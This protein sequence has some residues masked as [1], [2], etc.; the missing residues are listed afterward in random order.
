MARGGAPTSGADTTEDGCSL[1]SELLKAG[2]L[3]GRAIPKPLAVAPVNS[4]NAHVLRPAQ[5]GRA[6]R[7]PRFVSVY[8]LETPR[9]RCNQICP[10][11]E[12]GRDIRH[13]RLP[14]PPVAAS[15]MTRWFAAR[16]VQER[17]A[18]GV[19]PFTYFVRPISFIISPISVLSFF[20]NSAK[21]G[22]S[23]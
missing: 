4:S 13:A 9:S 5:L 3:A 23:A 19:P 7:R 16:S 18:I 1:T 17:A 20:M 12:N 21:P 8:R 2:H 6:I 11:N 14:Y 10:G 15:G 22:A